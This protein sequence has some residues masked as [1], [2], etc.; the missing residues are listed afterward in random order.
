MT[1]TAPFDG[2]GAMNPNP[3][4]PLL[5]VTMLKFLRVSFGFQDISHD[6]RRTRH[7]EHQSQAESKGTCEL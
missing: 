1:R 6:I 5:R 2:V 3:V 7:Y 4:F